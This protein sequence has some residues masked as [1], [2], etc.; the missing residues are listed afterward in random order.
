MSHKY[1][2]LLYA[3]LRVLDLTF[4]SLLGAAKKTLGQIFLILM[5]G[6]KATPTFKCVRDEADAELSPSSYGVMKI[7]MGLRLQSHE[8]DDVDSKSATPFSYKVA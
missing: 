6:S 2:L 4:A 8:S 7:Y 1:L 5:K 3:A